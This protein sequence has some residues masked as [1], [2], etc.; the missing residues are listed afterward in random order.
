MFEYWQATL[1]NPTFLVALA[2]AAVMAY[3]IFFHKPEGFTD[4]DHNDDE[5]DDMP[6]PGEI[7]NHIKD[8]HDTTVRA[9]LTRA[10]KLVTLETWGKDGTY[11][12]MKTKFGSQAAAKDRMRTWAKRL[13]P[14]VAK[15]VQL[16]VTTTTQY[17]TAAAKAYKTG[18]TS[19]V[20][21]A[22]KTTLVDFSSP[23]PKKSKTPAVY[24][25]LP[26]V[27][28][29]ATTQM[30]AATNAG[31]NPNTMP[32][33]A[34]RVTPG[35]TNPRKQYYSGLPGRR[36]GW[37]T[38]FFGWLQRKPM[39]AATAAVAATAVAGNPVPAAYATSLLL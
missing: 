15:E 24:T 13:L 23:K 29:N 33:N 31:V 28:M 35:R 34:P 10:G 17:G 2:I 3:F 26:V 19:R 12:V 27:P 1:T 14:V 18:K 32:T 4:N 6:T 20:P 11:D 39:A 7:E 9:T 8:V 22:T 38:S 36:V 30:L 5:E 16:D 25:T 37:W 21:K